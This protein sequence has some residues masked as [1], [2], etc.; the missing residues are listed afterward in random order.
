MSIA[1]DTIV[2]RRMDGSEATLADYRGQVLLLVN[3]ASKC[4]LTPQYEGLERLFQQYRGAGLTVI[5]FPANDFGAQEPGSNEQIAQFCSLSYGV[6]F[7]L[8]EKVSVKG[9][10][11]HPL[12]AALIAAAPMAKDPAQG[13][14]LA[15][16]AGYGIGH[17]HPSDVLWNFEK[18][19]VG[20]DGRVVARFNPDVAP[21]DP[22]LVSALAQALAK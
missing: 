5:G 9:P 12:Y 13:A 17:E 6:S 3:V 1:I 21:E 2:F 20:R 14:M 19:L 4:G 22:L 16:L 10:A 11:Q 8:A 7:P 18:F 15:K